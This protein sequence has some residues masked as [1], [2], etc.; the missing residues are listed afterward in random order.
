MFLISACILFCDLTFRLNVISSD[1]VQ[2]KNIFVK[3]FKTV[4]Y[5][6]L[7]T[8]FKLPHLEIFCEEKNGEINICFVYVLLDFA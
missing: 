5:Y 6:R 3:N 4:E 7:Y 1:R 8:D 2:Y